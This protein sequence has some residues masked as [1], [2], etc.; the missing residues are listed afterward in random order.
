[1]ISNLRRTWKDNLSG[2]KLQIDKLNFNVDFSSTACIEKGQTEIIRFLKGHFLLLVFIMKMSIDIE[3]KKR[4]IKDSTRIRQT[5]NMNQ[6]RLSSP[7]QNTYSIAIISK[8]PFSFVSGYNMGQ[9][10]PGG[11]RKHCCVAVPVHQGMSTRWLQNLHS[12]LP[13]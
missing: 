8:I 1:M 13:P 12:K 11:S 7:Y 3:R 4:L 9:G 10:L 6:F 5:R 2:F